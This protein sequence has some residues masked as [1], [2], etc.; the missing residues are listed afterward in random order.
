MKHY[1]NHVSQFAKF[2]K[3]RNRLT[4]ICIPVS[5]M[6]AFKHTG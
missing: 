5:V 1:L 4:G 6:L 3:K 2:H